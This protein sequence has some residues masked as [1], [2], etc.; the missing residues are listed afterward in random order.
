MI[1]AHDKVN[2]ESVTVNFNNFNASSLDILVNF[3]IRVFTGPEEMELQQRIFI[4]ILEIASRLKVD[5]AYPTQ[6]TYAK[7]LDTPTSS[8]DFVPTA[9]L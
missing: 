6:M 5:F 1:T 9:P 4:Q 2:P 3:H 8:K 7:N